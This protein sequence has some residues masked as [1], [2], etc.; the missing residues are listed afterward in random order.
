MIMMIMI[1]MVVMIND[2]DVVSL[3]LNSILLYK[4]MSGRISVTG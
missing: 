1:M 4:I 2:D 3:A